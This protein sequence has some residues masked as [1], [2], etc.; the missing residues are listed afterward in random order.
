[1]FLKVEASLKLMAAQ[2]YSALVKAKLETGLSVTVKIS[3]LIQQCF[4][5]CATHAAVLCQ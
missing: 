3:E 5:Y 1:M 4:D 2:S